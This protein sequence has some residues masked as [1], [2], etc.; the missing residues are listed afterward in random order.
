MSNAPGRES[1]PLPRGLGD[2]ASSVDSLNFA[3]YVEAL[4]QFLLNADPPL[5]VSIE[6][7]WG[8]GKSSFMRQ[9]KQRLD[10]DG[11][12]TVEFNPWRHRSE[13][14]LW[15]AFLLSFIAQV[16]GRLT[17]RDRLHARLSL[18][19][20]RAW[21]QWKR[22]ALRLLATA[23][24]ASV[25]V[26][27]VTALG[28]MLDADRLQTL[29]GSLG[30][31]AVSGVAF[32]AWVRRN[33]VERTET[34][35]R[36]QLSHETYEDRVAFVERFHDDFEQLL[37]AYVGRDRPV[38]VF[39]DDLDRCGVANVGELMESIHLMLSNDPRLVFLLGM[40]REKVAGAIA[41]RHGELLTYL[42]TDKRDRFGLDYGNQYL[43]K[44]V[45]IPFDIPRI[46]TESVDEFV[47]GITVASD[48]ATPG[49]ANLGV[50]GRTEVDGRP[51]EGSY[52]EAPGGS[53]NAAD[54]RPWLHRVLAQL[55]RT[56]RQST[57]PLST[58]V[59]RWSRKRLQDVTALVAP[60][61]DHNP[62]QLKRFV[63]LYALTALVAE[64]TKPDERLPIPTRRPGE[65]GRPEESV[66]RRETA[67][68]TGAT[69]EQIG[70]F[71]AVPL[72]WP[73][74]HAEVQKD[75]KLLTDLVLLA[76]QWRYW[77]AYHEERR[78]RGETHGLDGT[79]TGSSSTPS[80]SLDRDL[81]AIESVRDET[82]EVPA[83]EVPTLLNLLLAGLYDDSERRD[84]T[85]GDRRRAEFD[86]LLERFGTDFE[87]SE[88]ERFFEKIGPSNVE[89]ETGAK[90]AYSLAQPSVVESLL[91]VSPR[92]GADGEEHDAEIRRY[93][94]DV[95]RNPD[96][97]WL[98][99]RLAS[100]LHESG[101]TDAA[102]EQY[103]IALELD[104]R[105]AV[106]HDGYA[107]FLQDQGRLD[108]AADHLRTATQLDP[109]DEIK[110][111]AY[112]RLLDTDGRVD[113]ADEQ[114]REALSLN[115]DGGYVHESYAH[116]LAK[117][118]RD[119]EA[120]EQYRA[121]LEHDHAPDD[122]ATLR[123]SYARTLDWQGH[124]AEAEEQYAIA[125][126]LNPDDAFVRADYAQFLDNQARP[127][128]ADEQYRITLEG[129]LSPNEDAVVRLSYAEFLARQRRL[130]DAKT[131]FRIGLDRYPDD[132]WPRLGLARL[133]I[134]E[135]RYEEADQLYRIGL[136]RLPDEPWLRDGYA[137]L[138]DERGRPEEADEQHRAALD[139]AADEIDEKYFREN[140]ATFL[141]ERG[142]DEEADDQYRAAVELGPGDFWTRIKYANF[143][144]GRDRLEE[145]ETQYREALEL[146]S[147]DSFVRS[148]YAEFLRGQGR[149]DEADEV[150]SRGRVG[151]DASEPAT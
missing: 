35:L 34:E 14:A 139:R 66:K 150:E 77:E 17:A 76:L 135:E 90:S 37:D 130:D 113:E 92:T 86:R 18:L 67:T 60:T 28:T 51:D 58:T 36:S 126:R 104:E 114:F 142:R 78:R 94:R 95:E 21:S 121:A 73:R 56:P 127:D 16:S 132:P 41:A 1:E 23:V 75:P 40:D 116:F 93:L 42:N 30:V 112:A 62:R 7:E 53:R 6:G 88:R 31:T 64:K 82:Q 107:R 148:S 45:Q 101:Q 79:R 48:I 87:E 81:W 115:A 50:G 147:G 27:A 59:P 120:A 125:L 57:V 109:G 13:E 103:L 46:S 80:V 72:R 89:Q 38:F 44:F 20:V 91:E 3:P 10:E 134:D 32:L 5:T 146:A 19:R 123:S 122:E 108:L 29:L 39:V 33:V 12:V 15:A 128:E 26:L 117:H 96:A 97:A 102:E 145:A 105:D 69:L 137:R 71:V 74:F 119:H 63:N 11:H 68:P 83:D 100:L 144:R 118:G 151:S 84:T 138:L 124:I 143:L 111:V 133:L 98:R 85:T 149:E 140:Y 106:A 4:Q 8:A 22:V 141:A 129:D 61:L 65:P 2:T 9:L 136:E 110:A 52:A 55:R 131:Q 47:R 43:E 70:K 99:V 25:A 54:D 24:V 49:R